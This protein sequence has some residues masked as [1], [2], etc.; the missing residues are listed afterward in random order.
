[1]VL[2]SK[3]DDTSS[4]E[5]KEE[6]RSLYREEMGAVRKHFDKGNVG[7]TQGKASPNVV[8]PRRGREAQ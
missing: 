8:Y 5:R 3:K 2:K 4:A 7:A 1:M 6:R